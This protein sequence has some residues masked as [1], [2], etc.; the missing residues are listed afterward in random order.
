MK[1]KIIYILFLVLILAGCSVNADITIN[2]NMIVDENISILFDNS[3]ASN[4]DSTTRYAANYIE[5]YSSAISLKNY[6]YKINE[7]SVKTSVDFDKRSKNIC[8]SI[9][10]SL[11]S[12]YLYKNISCI[13]EN[14]YYIVKS[15]GNQ[16]VSVPQSKKKFNVENV[17]L[18]VKLPVSALENN[19]DSID[20]NIYT[21]NFD[22]N[23]SLDK[24]IYLKISKKALEKKKTDYDKKEQNKKIIKNILIVLGSLVILAIVCVVL[25]ILYKKYKSNKLEY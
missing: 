4:F 22:E 6:N 11:F 24:S 20:G 21:W 13:E 10:Y 1:N 14:D 9:N 25:N 3:L 5:Y 7:G 19:A 17:I 16:L 2:S 15:E 23:T 12:Q 8:D 18:N